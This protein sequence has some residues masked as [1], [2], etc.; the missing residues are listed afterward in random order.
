MSKQTA[1]EWIQ[2][3][4]EQEPDFLT[5]GLVLILI[6]QALQMEKEQI[7]NAWDSAYGGDSNHTGEQYYEQTYRG[8]L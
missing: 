3:Q 1:V 8:N 2:W 7:E 6:E 5:K 4:V